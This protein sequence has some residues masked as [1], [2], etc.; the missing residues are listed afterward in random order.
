MADAPWP[1]RSGAGAA[2][3]AS[4]PPR[5]LPRRSSPAWPARRTTR[6]WLP[7]STRIPMP[8]PS[9]CSI[10]R[11]P[12]SSPW[13][14][15]RIHATSGAVCRSA[16][17]V[18]AAGLVILSRRSAA[19]TAAACKASAGAVE[20]LAGGP[21]LEPRRLAHAGEGLRRLDLRSGAGCPGALHAGGPERQDRAGAR[22]RG[23]GLRRRVFDTCDALVSIPVRGRVG[24][25]NVSAAAAVLLF[26]AAR[27]RAAG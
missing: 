6:G 7:R 9:R 19:V 15:S 14:R 10:A 3:A 5:R 22:Q 13:T 18:G 17:A 2:F 1:R 16:E 21:G 26:E 27:Q 25:L 4:G 12:W 24:S 23:E 11:T 8:I 20:H